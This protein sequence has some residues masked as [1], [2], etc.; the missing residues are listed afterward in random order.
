MNFVSYNSC[1]V[2]F[3]SSTSSKHGT[4]VSK[5]VPTSLAPVITEIEMVTALDIQ[6]KLQEVEWNFS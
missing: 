2:A 1:C 3:N 6:G 4:T 5:D